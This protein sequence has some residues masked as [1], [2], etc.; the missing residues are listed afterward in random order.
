MFCRII[1]F[2]L[3]SVLSTLK[4]IFLLAQ[5]FCSTVPSKPIFKTSYNVRPSLIKLITLKH[6]VNMVDVVMSQEL[7]FNKTNY[8]FRIYTMG[9]CCGRCLNIFYKRF[10]HFMYV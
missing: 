3:N 9:N 10:V 7:I 2:K 4:N 5:K 6:L 8:F 1:N